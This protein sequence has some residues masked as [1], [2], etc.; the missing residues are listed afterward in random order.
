MIRGVYELL[1]SA[2]PRA[3]L[4]HSPEIPV[5]QRE[6]FARLPAVVQYVLRYPPVPGPEQREDIAL[7]RVVV[8]DSD[9]L[10]GLTGSRVSS[11]GNSFTTVYPFLS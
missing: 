5:Q 7:D 10:K 4:H 2:S 9:R 11:T 3:E 1:R 6:A 8:D